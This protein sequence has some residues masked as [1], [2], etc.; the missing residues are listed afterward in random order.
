MPSWRNRRQTSVRRRRFLSGG[1]QFG[2][3]LLASR[4]KS[5]MRQKSRSPFIAKHFTFFA[6]AMA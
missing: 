3:G 6:I 2:I 4:A 1:Q 5:T